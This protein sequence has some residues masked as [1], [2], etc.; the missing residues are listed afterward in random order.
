[1]HAFDA[2]VWSV[3]A[4]TVLVTDDHGLVLLLCVDQDGGSHG[5]AVKRGESGDRAAGEEAS[6]RDAG[7]AAGVAAADVRSRSQR[8]CGSCDDG[9]R[10]A[11]PYPV[12]ECE[13]CFLPAQDEPSRARCTLPRCRV[14]THANGRLE[15]LQSQRVCLP[16]LRT[17]NH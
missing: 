17:P 12:L 14:I 16:Q 4:V 5:G 15:I 11:R 13:G 7:M 1:M 3:W 10:L 2:A 8:T 6:W 9:I